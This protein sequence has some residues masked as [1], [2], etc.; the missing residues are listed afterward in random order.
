VPR[1]RILPRRG[2]SPACVCPASSCLTEHPRVMTNPARAP[3]GLELPSEQTMSRPTAQRIDPIVARCIRSD[4]NWEHTPVPFARKSRVVPVGPTGARSRQR[5]GHAR[6]QALSGQFHQLLGN[7]ETVGL[8]E[9][10]ILARPFND[11]FHQ[12]VGTTDVEEG[13][14]LCSTA[15]WVL[16]PPTW[17]A[18]EP[19]RPKHAWI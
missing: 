3:S 7:I 9:V 10:T 17:P 13:S 2:V 12:T 8:D 1:R 5:F 6:E 16:S 11:A 4:E 15:Q 14:S 18:K 19:T